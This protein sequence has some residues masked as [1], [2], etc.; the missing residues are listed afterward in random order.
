M[1]KFGLNMPQILKRYAWIALLLALTVLFFQAPAVLSAGEGEKKAEDIKGSVS[2]E[3]ISRDWGI[4]TAYLIEGLKLPKDV[5]LNLALKELK[6]RHGFTMEDVRKLVADYQASGKPTQAASASP[7]NKKGA[8]HEGEKKKEGVG[9]PL[10]LIWNPLPGRPFFA[11]G[12]KTDQPFGRMDIDSL[13]A[14]FRSLFSGRIPSPCGRSS[15][16]SSPSPSACTA[17]NLPSWCFWPSPS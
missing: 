4:P 3:T 1:E 10:A 11:Q 16:F 7:A 15:R 2:L 13:P 6:D 9:L 5:S 8:G 14:D 12:E 17:C